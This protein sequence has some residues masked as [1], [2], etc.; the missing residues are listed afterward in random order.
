MCSFDHHL[1][2]LKVIGMDQ[3]AAIYNVFSIDNPELNLLLCVY[4]LKNVI[5]KN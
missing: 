3:D 2:N 5:P 4:H 1:L